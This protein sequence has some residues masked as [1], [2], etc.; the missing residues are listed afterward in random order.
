MGINSKCSHLFLSLKFE[1][2]A[3]EFGKSKE[4]ASLS[5]LLLPT[6]VGDTLHNII[7]LMVALRGFGWGWAAG[8]L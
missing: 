8:G 2:L 7:E 6:A 5:I 1:K 4:S 3:A